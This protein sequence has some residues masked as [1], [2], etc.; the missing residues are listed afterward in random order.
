MARE[1]MCYFF[2]TMTVGAISAKICIKVMVSAKFLNGL[3]NGYQPTSSVVK[4]LLTLSL[5]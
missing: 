1:A 4:Q 2:A 3:R 5:I